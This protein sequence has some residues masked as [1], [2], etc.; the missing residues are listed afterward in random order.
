M[1]IIYDKDEEIYQVFENQLNDTADNTAAYFPGSMNMFA[2]RTQAKS[3]RAMPQRAQLGSP[4]VQL[5]ARPISAPREA[6]SPFK[7]T[8]S[9]DLSVQTK[10]VPVF[11]PSY[12]PVSRPVYQRPSRDRYMYERL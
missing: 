1:I 2:N 4:L 12:Q 10:R 11:S 3:V 9:E 8:V 6:R 5:P 7:K